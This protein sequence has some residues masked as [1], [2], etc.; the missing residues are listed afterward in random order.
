ATLNASSCTFTENQAIGSAGGRGDGGALYNDGRVGGATAVV[1]NCNFLANQALGGD[2]GKVTTQGTNIGNGFG[3][4]IVNQKGATLTVMNSR[5]TGNRAIGGNGG[6]GGQGASNYSIDLGGGGAIFVF[7]ATLNLS[8]SM[9]SGNQAVGGSNAISGANG[10]GLV[11]NG[12]GAAVVT[13]GV[14]A[15]T[16]TT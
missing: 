7:N 3:G 6:S 13:N 11:G 12:W 16:D 2:G 15:I 9:F 5:F 10:V 4:G 1:S 14:V 8:G